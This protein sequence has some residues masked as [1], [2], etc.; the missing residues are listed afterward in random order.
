[1]ET[2][3]QRLPQMMKWM[4]I[5]PEKVTNI[6]NFGSFVHKTNSEHSDRDVLIVADFEQSHRHFKFIGNCQ[7]PYFHRF[8]MWSFP[9]D[10]PKDVKSEE[11]QS[12]TATDL[13]I[14]SC[15]TFEKLLEANYMIVVECLFY[16]EEFK[17]KND[18]DW[19]EVYLTQYYDPT[20]IKHALNCE[21]GYSH[22]YLKKCEED[23]QYHKDN[24]YL[25]L[26]RLFNMLK[27]FEI[28]VQLLEFKEIK[29][30][31]RSADTW[32]K[33]KEAYDNHFDLKDIYEKIIKPLELAFLEE[34][35]LP[36]SS[37]ELPNYSAD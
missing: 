8:K 36:T 25:T 17:I 18:R 9:R 22:R 4:G 21:R 33:I 28:G 15:A 23:P 7:P 16:P 19:K 24:K 29:E 5:E 12:E 2:L 32:L 35:N 26:K 1:M 13:T 6:F 34:L 31:G 3:K 10:L 14:Y 11:T 30:F 37:I 27:Y 20:R